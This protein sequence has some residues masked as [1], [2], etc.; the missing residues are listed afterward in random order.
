VTEDTSVLSRLQKQNRHLRLYA[1]TDERFCAYGQV[2]SGLDVSAMMSNM[3]APPV[4]ETGNVYVAS[5][6]P[7]EDSASA[8]VVA[9]VLGGVDT[10][11]GY[12]NG[13]NSSL[14]GLEYHKSSELNVA[15]TDLVLLLGHMRDIHQNRYHAER[16]DAFY[17]PRATAFEIFAGTL[18]YGPCKVWPSGFKC[19]V[20]LPRGTNL[21]FS[22]PVAKTEGEESHLLFRCNK[23]LLVHPDRQEQ[24]LDGA[25]PGI[26][27]PNIHV[28][29]LQENSVMDL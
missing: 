23:W 7:L 29:F 19:V 5:W 16:V 24:V 28:Q 17:V 3:A 25:N 26:D 6:K 27:G 8:A 4:P 13:V 18:H 15:V 11:I 10:Q 9:G 1:V 2:L 14:N 22:E 20:A 21:P 12:C